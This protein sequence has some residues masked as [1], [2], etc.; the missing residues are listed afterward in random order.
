MS[1]SW[2]PAISQAMQQH[3]GRNRTPAQALPPATEPAPSAAPDITPRSTSLQVFPAGSPVIP[4]RREA[5]DPDTGN[6]R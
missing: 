3:G 1:P 2:D 4:G 5:A 6:A